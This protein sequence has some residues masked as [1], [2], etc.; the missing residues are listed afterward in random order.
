MSNRYCV[1]SVAGTAM[2]KTNRTERTALAPQPSGSTL[3]PNANDSSFK[4]GNRACG[5]AMPASISVPTM[6]SRF[7]AA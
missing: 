5:N 1:E 2:R 4:P 6:N 7:N 3:R